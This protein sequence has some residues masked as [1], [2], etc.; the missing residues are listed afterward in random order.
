MMNQRDPKIWKYDWNDE[1]EDGFFQCSCIFCLFIPFIWKSN[2]KDWNPRYKKAKVDD[3]ERFS[4]SKPLIQTSKLKI[5]EGNK[6]NNKQHHP[7]KSF[8]LLSKNIFK[9]THT[10]TQHQEH[11]VKKVVQTCTGSKKNLVWIRKE[12][13]IWLQFQNP[14]RIPKLDD[15]IGVV[16]P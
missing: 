16:G 14:K 13:W 9:H 8:W 7:H 10:H 2:I 12:E 1:E 3:F 11:T 5:E 4:E 15:K 6:S